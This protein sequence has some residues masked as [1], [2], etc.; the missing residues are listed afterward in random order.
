MGSQKIAGAPVACPAMLLNDDTC[1]FDMSIFSRSRKKKEDRLTRRDAAG[2]LFL[3]SCEL[4]LFVSYLDHR[5]L[6]WS[7]SSITTQNAKRM[8][9]TKKLILCVKKEHIF[10]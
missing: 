7:Q 3:V 4:S 5:K 2:V 9:Q 1:I 10:P 6:P 8:V